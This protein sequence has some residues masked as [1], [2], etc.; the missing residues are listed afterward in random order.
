MRDRNTLDLR[1]RRCLDGAF[2]TELERQ[3]IPID[4]PL[5]SAR[6]LQEVPGAV[7]G[8]HR[9]YLHA[10]A[11]V[12]L[13][14]SYQVSS[15]GYR[16]TGLPANQAAQAAADALRRS[17][18]LAGEAQ[19]QAGRSDV[20]IAASLGPYGAALANG[21]EFHGEYG[22]SSDADEH[23]A[24][25]A[26]HA[27]RIA[28]LAETDADLLAFETLPS[29]AEARAIEEALRGWPRL[30]AWLSFI[31]RDGAHTA[32]GEPVRACAALAEASPQIVAV[33]VNCT[34]PAWVLPLIGELRASTR[35][36]IVVYPNSGEGW[37]AERRCWIEDTTN[38]AGAAGYE[39]LAA[40]WFRAGAQLVGGCCRT[41][42]A[43][44]RA[45]RAAMQ[46]LVRN[47]R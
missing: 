13:T 12:L 15:V 1:G 27:E 26:F 29:L 17:V 24:L 44:T 2:A 10:G 33:G 18:A 22:F 36:P 45:V 30:G 14:G 7:V 5:W 21:A 41:G 11:D 37:D 43:H 32:H 35:K 16:A 8:V 4:G 28:V 23:A 9:T 19:A 6:A 42:P 46:Q 25:V 34:A 38:K 20:L 3:G 39:A 40:G 47:A 31:C